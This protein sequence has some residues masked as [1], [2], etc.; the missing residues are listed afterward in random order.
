[1][2][3]VH[4]H[5]LYKK[6]LKLDKKFTAKGYSLDDLSA[7][8]KSKDSFL[9]LLVLLIKALFALGASDAC[10]ASNNNDGF[11]DDYADD[12]FSLNV[13]SPEVVFRSDAFSAIYRLEYG[14]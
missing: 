9:I 12:K 3:H 8:L 5:R 13:A 6:V 11:F 1:M 10:D 4:T 7:I 2:S 14:L